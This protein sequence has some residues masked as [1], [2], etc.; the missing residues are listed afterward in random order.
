MKNEK[1]EL[2]PCPFCGSD[3]I[4]ISPEDKQLRLSHVEC[5]G[6]GIDVSYGNCLQSSIE[7]WNRRVE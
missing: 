2:L 7:I 4:R 5:H 1:F 3:D 6:C